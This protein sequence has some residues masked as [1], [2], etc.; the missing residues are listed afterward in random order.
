TVIHVRDASRCVGVVDRLN[1]PELKGECDR[2][3]RAD[4]EGERD[5]FSRRKQRKLVPYAE[6]LARRFATDWTACP[7]STPSFLGTRVLRA[8]PL[9]E[10]GPYID[11]SPFFMSWELKGKYPAILSDPVVGVEATKLFADAQRLLE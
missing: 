5:N 6:A 1:R 4:Q 10:I 9:A 7:I 8:A 11:W 2:Q 3:N